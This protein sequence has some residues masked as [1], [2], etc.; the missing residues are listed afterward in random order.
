MNAIFISYSHV[1]R[2]EVEQLVLKLKDIQ[3]SGWLDEADI[4]WGEE[5]KAVLKNSLR[6]AN[7]I[8]VL[9]SPASVHSGWVEFEIGAGQSLGKKIIPV[10]IKGTDIEMKLPDSLKDL[11]Y[12]DARNLNVDETIDKIKKM[13]ST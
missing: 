11:V 1:D 6:Q 4:A 5:V 10:I 13:I 9:I 12:I 3:I 8:L 7:A 2:P